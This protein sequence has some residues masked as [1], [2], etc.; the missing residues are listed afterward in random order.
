LD[1][2][3]SQEVADIKLLQRKIERERKA[4]QIAEQQ[5]EVY[6]REIYQTNQSLKKSLGYAKKKHAEIEYLTKASNDV[7]SELTL[8]DI[9]ENTVSLTGKFFKAEYGINVIFDEQKLQIGSKPLIWS[10]DD[11]WSENSELEAFF[12]KYFPSAQSSVSPEWFI[13]P[14]KY[15]DRVSSQNFRWVVCINF[16]LE[17]DS[18]VWI[19]FL[20]NIEFLDEVALHVLEIAK[21]HLQSAIRMRLADA[22]IDRR[23]IQLQETAIDLEETRK[24]LI[25]SEKMSSLGQLAAGVA[26]E[27]NNPIGYIQANLQVLDDYLQEFKSIFTSLEEKVNLSGSLSKQEFNDVAKIKEMDFLLEDS[28]LILKTNLRGVERI[29]EIV[30]DL[31][32]FSHAGDDIHK[33]ISIYDCVNTA[34]RVVAN[35]FK[36]QHQ[37]INELENTLPKVLGNYGQLQQVFINLLINSAHS[38]PNGGIIK[39]YSE[40]DKHHLLLHFKDSGVGMDEK[41]KKQIFNPFFTTKPIGQGTGLGLSVSYAILESQNVGI[42]VHSELG[43][44]SCFTLRF[45]ID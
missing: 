17:N 21:S 33:Q 39:I 23:N 16:Q 3:Q 42:S 8:S 25:Q 29:K 9:L 36:Y 24:Q 40:L 14:I 22:R 18:V 5:L 15:G 12:F 30:D 19:G 7:S 2:N 45:P 35:E 38:M 27:M 43:K 41:T 44:G 31:R 34:L 13:I 26:H 6:S 37:V 4:R 11:S 32:S 20:T 10:P 28:N 1:K